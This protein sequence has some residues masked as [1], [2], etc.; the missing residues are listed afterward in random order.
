MDTP[1]SPMNEVLLL[2]GELKAQV[3][4]VRDDMQ[5]VKT[6][7]AVDRRDSKESRQRIYDKLEN[8]ERRLTEMEST[9][10]VLGGV[11]EKSGQRLDRLEPQVD[12]A[13]RT[14]RVWTVRGGMIATAMAALG[15]FV[16][17]M[18]QSNGPFVW[19]EVLKLLK[20]HP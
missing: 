5:E 4:G 7:A 18:V 20:G 6:E 8:G 9:V 15:G 2:L 3:A 10:R 17:W 19:G 11:I 12:R 13:T 14:I 16:W 1:R